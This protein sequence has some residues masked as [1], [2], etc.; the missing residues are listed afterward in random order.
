[1]TG[2]IKPDDEESGASMN[3]IFQKKISNF[4]GKLQMLEERFDVDIAE[5][6]NLKS[7]DQAFQGVGIS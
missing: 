6:F 4:D 7:R 3:Q 5:L 2:M 1:M